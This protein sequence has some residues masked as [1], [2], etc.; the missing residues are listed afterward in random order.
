MHIIKVLFL[1]SLLSISHSLAIPFKEN[2]KPFSKTIDYLDQANP[3]WYAKT[4]TTLL[5]ELRR[6]TPPGYQFLPEIAVQ[7]ILDNTD[8][9]YY[10]P[11]ANKNN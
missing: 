8:T 4:I 6:K 2:A 3:K 9:P 10:V 1:V 5:A 7:N 11:T